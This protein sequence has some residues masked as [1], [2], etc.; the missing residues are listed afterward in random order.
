MIENVLTALSQALQQS[1][2]V[3]L[4]AALAWGMAS[5]LLSPCHLSSIPLIIGF[6]NQNSSMQS[7]RAFVFS[8]LFSLGIL[9]SI[10]FIG[11]ITAAIGRMLGDIGRWGN[12]LVAA[13]FLVFG[14]YLMDLLPLSWSSLV[15]TDRRTG[16]VAAFSLGLIF[17]IGLGPCTFAFIAPVLGVVF[18]RAQSDLRSAVLLL[19]MF[20]VG[21][22]GIIVLAGTLSSRV[23][24]YLNWTSKSNTVMWLKRV[25]GFLVAMAGVYWLLK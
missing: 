17:G 22:C 21:H 11:I 24:A 8:L 16:P 4:L 25:C 13:V 19:A 5:I 3:S 15:P 6:L 20:A 12:L 7:R 2:A 9:I 10:A 23:Q 18:S 1:L 14:L